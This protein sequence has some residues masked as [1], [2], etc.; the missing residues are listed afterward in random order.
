MRLVAWDGV[1][2]RD[3]ETEVLE[4]TQV[5]VSGKDLLSRNGTLKGKIY[6]EKARNEHHDRNYGHCAQTWEE[7]YFYGSR[8][9]RPRGTF[10]K[11]R[12]ILDVAVWVRRVLPVPSVQRP[13]MPLNVPQSTAQPPTT[14]E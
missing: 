7:V 14:K 1:G 9:L 2:G 8:Q 4:D 13:G 6:M 11:T 10:G 12:T 3:A 5:D